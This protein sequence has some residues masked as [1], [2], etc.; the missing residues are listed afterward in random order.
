LA[1]KI[2]GRVVDISE[3]GDAITD[4]GLERLKS[5]PQDDQVTVT[6]GGH[7]TSRIFPRE[8]GQPEMTFLAVHGSTGFL[9]LHLVGD[10]A[11]A[12]LGLERGNEVV[13]K[14]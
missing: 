5:V 10:S 4:I 2:Q 9:E 1:G 7:V 8:H 14:W 13:I 11:C 12:F 3:S 6:C